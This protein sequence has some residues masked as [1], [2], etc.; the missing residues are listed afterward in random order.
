M[1]RSL[2]SPSSK[3][4]AEP[5]EGALVPGSGTA[6]H[7]RLAIVMAFAA[8]YIIWGSTYLAIRYAVET[9][10][11]LLM[12]GVRFIVAGAI[13]AGIYGPR[14]TEKLTS[15][16]WRR[17]GV[18]GVLLLLGGNGL[19]CWAELTVPSGLAALLVATMP[20][21]MATLDWA[22]FGGPRPSRAVVFG[23]LTG[24]GG[25]YILIGDVPLGGAGAD[26][27]GTIALLC[28][29]VFW[30]VGSLIA[31]RGGLPKSTLLATGMEMLVGGA[32]LV[33]AGLVMGEATRVDLAAVSW[34]SWVA[35]AYL[36]VFGSLLGFTAYVYLLK[37]TTP[38]KVA[39]YAYV[40][41]AIAV[42][43]GA[44]FGDGE[45]SPRVMAAA[46]IILASVVLILRSAHP[47]DK[48]QAEV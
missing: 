40:N 11:P 32:A 38:S 46:A 8:V 22:F 36:I 43:L 42:A 34:K 17:A 47:A 33:A 31:R 5:V 19:V 35:W 27:G 12:A 1:A 39:T 14:S 23:L 37:A 7:S 18:V 24:L 15:A 6:E 44:A 26:L 21:W 48:Q 20:L 3:T 2:E 25:V 13:L 28:A 41:P 16:H 9:L 30:T 29:C 45:L 4:V 10:P